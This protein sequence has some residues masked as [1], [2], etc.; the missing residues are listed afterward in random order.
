[1]A[2]RLN[3]Q[4]HTLAPSSAGATRKKLNKCLKR[5]LVEWD[6]DL[7]RAMLARMEAEDAKQNAED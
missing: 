5:S 3:E 4:G 1:M 2:S 7:P 6:N